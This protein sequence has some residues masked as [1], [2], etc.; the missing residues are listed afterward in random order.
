MKDVA[1]AAGVGLGTVSRVF[2]G[3]GPVANATR[4]RIEATAAR[5]NYRPSA[6]GRDL[7]SMRTR[8][9]GL[10]VADIANTFYGE[11]TEGV[12]A[13]A[14]SADRHVII[15]ATGEDPGVERDYIEL[16]LGQRPEGII[17]F[18]TGQNADLWREA[19]DAG[20]R[21]VF[22]DR[23]VESIPAPVVLS[24][25]AGSAY[26]LTEYLLA[27]GHSRIGYLGGPANVYTA[28][29]RESGF[30]RAHADAG[31]QVAEHLVLRSRFTRGLAHAG[32]A[33]LLSADP[34]PT[35]VFASNNVLG[36]EVLGA[37]SVAGLRV[38]RDVSFVMFDDVPWAKLTRPDVTVIAQPTWAMG[39]EALRLVIEQGTAGPAP[40]VVLNSK[41]IVRG[42]AAPPA[43]PAGQFTPQRK[44][45]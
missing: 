12:L 34:P 18:P 11:F 44:D 17:A 19:Q 35:A 9:V 39:R 40:R 15:G 14:A 22:A 38:P 36:E 1:A 25:N 30:R 21:V 32:A 4:E 20:I 2:S 37:L 43:A 33:R 6:L 3:G 24:D 16:M 41:L 10:M 28:I 7:R 45:E 31:I 29:E 27:L 26:A 5:L 42:S 8:N 13:A 23:P